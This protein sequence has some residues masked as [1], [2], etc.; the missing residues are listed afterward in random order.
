MVQI[1]THFLFFGV[2][3]GESTRI[4]LFLIELRLLL[5]N[6]DSFYILTL[7]NVDFTSFVQFRL[8]ITEFGGLSLVL[9]EEI[10]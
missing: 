3:G 7:E 9:L 2:L 10:V 5:F 8:F 6:F 1:E 4:L